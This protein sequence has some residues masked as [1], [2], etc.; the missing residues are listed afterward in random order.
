[1]RSDLLSA[2]QEIAVKFIKEAE[3]SSLVEKIS[4]SASTGSAIN[5]SEML[6]SL[7]SNVAGRC[8]LGSTYEG[9]GW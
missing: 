2:T 5:L 4:R 3:V 6:G 8:T 9:G 1:M 7:S